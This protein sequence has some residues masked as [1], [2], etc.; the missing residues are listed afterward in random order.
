MKVERNGKDVTYC[1][2]CGQI[3]KATLIDG[4]SPDDI[5][6]AIAHTCISCDIQLYVKLNRSS[7][8]MAEGQEAT[9]AL[10]QSNMKEKRCDT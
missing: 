7:M 6:V 1:C 8:F 4:P 3:H 9:Q 2:S 5:L 10:K